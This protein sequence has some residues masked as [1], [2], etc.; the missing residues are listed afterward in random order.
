MGDPAA[1]ANQKVIKSSNS[2]IPL[3]VT[4]NHKSHRT[5]PCLQT[6]CSKR[7]IHTGRPVKGPKLQE[8]SLPRERGSKEDWPK[9]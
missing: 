9:K 4:S 1:E 2:G 7:H 6:V 5:F 8:K 3:V